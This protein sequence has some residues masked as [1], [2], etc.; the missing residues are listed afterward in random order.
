M[1]VIDT[2]EFKIKEPS[3]VTL[4]NFDGIHLG[5][6]ELIRT[7]LD[8]SERFRLRS[9]VFS[10][11]PH[12]VE[13]FGRQGEF[14]TMFSADEKKY[15]IESLGVDILVRYPFDGAFASMEPEKFMDLL[16]AKTNCLV[17]VVGENYCF[18]HDRKGNIDTLKELGAERGVKVIGIPRVKIDDVRVSSTRIRGLIAEG[19]MEYTARLLNKPYFVIG[20]VQ[21]GENRGKS[22]L[23]FPTINMTP[24]VKKLLPPDGV[25]F[26]RTLIDGRL[27]DSMSNI[28]VN[29]T[30]NGDAKKIETNIFNFDSEIYGKTAVVGFYKRIRNEQKF[31]SADELAIQLEKDRNECLSY[32]GMNYLSRYRL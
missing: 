14:K 8:Y 21:H 5:H 1:K 25:Y 23:N 4:G 6:Q 20:E 18:G 26:S 24:P 17:L 29:P 13:F 30:F 12:P 16:V 19:N 31:N 28:G 11:S 15:I 10:F 9:V 3:A 7:V 22:V 27:Y 32:A 2:T